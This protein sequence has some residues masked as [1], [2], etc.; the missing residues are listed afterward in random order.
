MICAWT[1]QYGGRCA[2]N[3]SSS[4]RQKAGKDKRALI[5]CY[6]GYELAL[7]INISSSRKAS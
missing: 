3:C 2:S 4:R 7:K 1:G 5:S 6:G